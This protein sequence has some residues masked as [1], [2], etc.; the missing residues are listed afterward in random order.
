VTPLA[1]AVDGSNNVYSVSSSSLDFNVYLAGGAGST[2]LSSVAPTGVSQIAVDTQGNLYAV[3]SGSAS[4]TK[5]TVTAPQSPSSAPPTYTAGTVPYPAVAPTKPQ[6]IAVDGEGNL[7]VSDGSTKAVYKFSPSSTYVPM[8]TVASGFGN[9]TLLAVDNFDNVFIYDAGVGSII[10]YIF[11]YTSSTTIVPSVT[12]TGLATDAAG[13]LYVQTVSGV[14][15]YPVSGASPVTVYSGGSSPNGIATDGSGNLYLSDAGNAGIVEVKRGSVSYNFGTGSSGSPTLTGTLTNAGNQ[16]VTGSSN[17]SNFTIAP[18][19]SNGCNFSASLLGSQAI[20]NACSFAANFVG[21]GSG[22]VNNTFTYLPTSTVGSLSLSGTLTGLA[23]ATTTT[24]SAPSPSNPSYS[25][26]AAEVT[27]TVTVVAQSGSSPPTG[28]VAIT[29]DSDAPTNY[30]LTAI[31]SSNPQGATATVALAGLT[32]TNHTISATYPTTGSFTTSSYSGNPVP[33]SIAADS[34]VAV[35]TPVTNSGQYSAPIGTSVLNATAT[36]NSA[37]VPGTF[38]Y[39]ANGNEIN[40]ASYLLI[41]TYTLSA[42]F[43]PIDNVDYTTATVSGG[44]FTVSKASTTAAVGTTQNLVA[45]DSTGNFTNVQ[46]AINSLPSTGGSVY[47]KPG[48]YAGFLTV[49]QPNVALRGLGGDPTQVILTHEAGAFGSTY[50]YTGEFQATGISAG[51][52]GSNG[53]Q[54]PNGSTISTGD[55]GS[56]TL[57]VARAVN[58]AVSSSTLTPINFYAENLSLIN[59]YNTDTTTTTTTYEPTTN[60]TCTVLAGPP[61]TYSYLYNNQFECGSQALAIWIES[62]QAVLNNVYTTSQQDTI[63]A[64][65]ISTGGGNSARQYWFRGKVTGDVDFIFGDAAAVFDHTTVYTTYHGNTATGTETIEAQNKANQTGGSSDYLSGYIMDGDIFTSQSPGMTNLFFGRPYANYSTWVMLNSYVDQVNATGYTTGL[66]PSLTDATYAEYNDQVYT[67]PATGSRDTNGII[68]LGA[69]GN[70]GSGVASTRETISTNPGTLESAA[71]G[72]QAN[73]P[74]FA[75]T[76]LSPAEAQQY[77]PMAFLG[78]TVPTSTYNTVTNWNPTAAIAADVNAFVPSGTSAT[79]TAGSSV[80][81][82]M[83]PQTP[84]LGAVTNGVYTIPTGTYTLTD[85]VN[86]GAS[87]TLASGT[88]DAAGEAYYTSSTLTAGTHNLTWTYSGDS[89]FSGSTTASAYVLTVTGSAAVGTTTAFGATVNPIGYGQ[90][91]SI[92]ATVSPASGTT[93]PAGSVNLTIDG[94]TT[95]TA[96]L[97]SGTASFTVTGL[98]AGGHVLSATYTGATAFGPSSTSPSGNLSLTVNKAALTVTGSCSNRIFGQANVCSA[99]VTGGYQYSDSAATVFTSAPTGTTTAARNSPAASYTA[100]PVYTPT[101]FGSTNYTIAPVNSSFTVAGG[102]A[103]SIIFAPLPNFAH[104][105][106]Y[107]L[108]ARS[109]SGLPVSYSIISTSGNASVSGST[110]TVTGTGS[111]TVQASQSIDPTGDYAA[112]TPVSMSFTAQ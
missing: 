81:I 21:T 42:T 7:Y 74:T 1:V 82:L 29:V 46:A 83:R 31:G 24:I 93:T 67:D 43:Y 66:G 75:N 19:S 38:V 30:P 8:Q 14:T 33:F 90:S 76:T 12:A 103:Q 65:A 28:V 101:A 96:P 97:S 71:G 32:A 88:L 108:T 84:G 44:T 112:A 69:G 54:L 80:T 72:F 52:G 78:A 47:I 20:G 89:N 18:G 105:A 85:S 104:G 16:A 4:I 25:P 70:T 73:Y 98:G 51:N 79:I 15:E 49:V 41:G 3:G 5:L 63:Y 11:P 57:F 109:T 9:P 13:D 53:W 40:P 58:T 6:G 60:G 77:Y 87:I 102:A 110:L 48:T 10:K 111:V 86:G 56:S 34:P 91:A 107:Q 22:T 100:T 36:F 27:F 64:G 68:Y 50:P 55:S 61:Q 94:T 2:L 59:A 45:S 95:L 62:D 92:T 39:K 106:S 35:W 26:S 99:L 37:P 17:L 23:I